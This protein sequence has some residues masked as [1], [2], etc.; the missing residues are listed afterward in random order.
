MSIKIFHTADLHIGMKFNAYPEPVR[1]M[2][3]QAR[4]KVLGRMVSLANESNCNLFVISG[5]L[6]HNIKGID[7]KTI[8][9]CAHELNLFQGECVLLLPGNH[10]Y[11]QEIIGFWQVFKKDADD[12]LIFLGREEP[13]SLSNYG[14]DVTIYPAPCHSKHSDTHNL[15]WISGATI[16]TGQINIGVAHGSLE[17]LSPDLDT[18]YYYMTAKDLERLPMDVWLL[19]HTHVAWPVGRS[20]RDWRMFNPGT[21]EPDG[22]DCR[23][24]GHA[25]LIEVDDK[26]VVTAELV[27]TGTFRFI[28]EHHSITCSDDL[29]RLQGALLSENPETLVARIHLTG[30]V[31]EET[32][33]YLRIVAKALEQKLACLFL[34]DFELGIKISSDKIAREFTDGSFPQQLLH[35]LADD[36]DA[37]QMACELMMEV[38]A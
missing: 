25:W 28:D 12:K 37:L 32:Y 5:D 38:R 33:E 26:H 21:P 36:E 17:G 4:S 35:A 6:F 10:D 11:Y 20:V 29:E 14:L 18:R 8:A 2:L 13:V 23:H 9:Q 7:K 1:G 27:Q 16:D 24:Q 34:D 30:R 15:G 31:P 19:G 3:Q 22:L